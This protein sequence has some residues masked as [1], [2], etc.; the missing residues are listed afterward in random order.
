MKR[1]VKKADEYDAV[2]GW[3]R[4]Y[5]WRPGQLAAIKRRLRR[6][7]RHE[8]TWAV[9]SGCTDEGGNDMPEKKQVCSLCNGYGTVPILCHKCGGYGCPTCRGTG[10]VGTQTCTQCHGSG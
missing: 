1:S 9:R 6:R 2:T 3:R 10:Q 4:F 7:E 8:A 5:C